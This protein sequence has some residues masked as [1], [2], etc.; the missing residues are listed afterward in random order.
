MNNDRY[1]AAI[2]HEKKDMWWKKLVQMQLSLTYSHWNA[3]V[4]VFTILFYLN[5]D[6]SNYIL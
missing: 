3:S 6:F 2:K 4:E 5:I 1:H